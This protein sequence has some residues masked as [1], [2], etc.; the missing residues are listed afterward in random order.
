MVRQRRMALERSTLARPQAR[1]TPSRALAPSQR[2]WPQH[3]CLCGTSHDVRRT[4]AACRQQR[5]TLQRQSPHQSG[6]TGVALTVPG[7]PPAL[8][9][10]PDVGTRALTESRSGYDFGRIHMHADVGTLAA[11][12]TGPVV[13]RKCACAK[14]DGGAACEACRRHSTHGALNLDSKVVVSDPSDPLEHE[15]D[16]IADA[17]VAQ[18]SVP[19]SVSTPPAAA[20]VQRQAERVV[21]DEEVDRTGEIDEEIAEIDEDRADESGR[22]KLGS[23]AS[24]VRTA[25]D[26][27][28]PSSSG[29]PLEAGVRR[30][31]ESRF[32]RDFAAVRVHANTGAEAAARSLDARAFTVG[33]HIYFGPGAGS[34][35]TTERRRLLA[36]ELVH[37]VQQTRG[38]GA[39]RIQRKRAPK[40]IAA[41][42]PAPK[43]KKKKAPCATAE[44]TAKN[45]IGANPGVA[46][47]PWCGNE[48]CATSGPANR[49]AFIRHL[50]VNLTDQM[51]IAELGTTKAATSAVGPFLSSP[52]PSE[53]PTGSH[54][55]GTKCTRCHTNMKGEGMAWFTSFHNGYEIG[56]HDSQKVK[57]GT[58]SH[59]CVRVPCSRAQWIRD[60]TW[61]GT[62]T[63][64]VHTGDHCKRKVLKDKPA[65]KEPAKKTGKPGKATPAPPGPRLPAPAPPS[66]RPAA[67]PVAVST[68][69]EEEEA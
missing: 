22:P 30:F 38:E 12:R 9:Q 65:E 69:G 51:V 31:M 44:C 14:A 61:S 67:V 39:P 50:D 2:G 32:R 66:G 26:V 29:A 59:G 28:P 41:P 27:A 1:L 57:K 21:E 36:H 6:P 45:C 8:I 23:G 68:T 13:Q 25:W 55:I 20:V 17:V 10:P 54:V 7:V 43:A 60:N 15:A 33:R 24:Q 52:N 46:H 19:A 4:C 3:T 5:L 47:H 11:V 63:V 37:V 64:C 62:T 16:R 56:F 53:T 35:D 58:F 49:T 34:G 40:K 18:R 48:A 42:R